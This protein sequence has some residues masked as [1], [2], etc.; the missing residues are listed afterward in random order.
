MIVNW[1]G[2]EPYVVLDAEL[3][4]N[5]DEVDPGICSDCADRAWLRHV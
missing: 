3:A 5:I 2:I 1:V 4:L